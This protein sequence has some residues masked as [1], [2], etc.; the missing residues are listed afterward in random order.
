MTKGGLANNKS[1][2]ALS[3]GAISNILC[4]FHRRNAEV[5]A[6]I[7]D[8]C[9]KCGCGTVSMI[10]RTNVNVASSIDGPTIFHFVSQFWKPKKSFP[11]GTYSLDLSY[12]RS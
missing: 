10:V 3:V 11:R 4:G 8:P 1:N 5:N 12:N 9:D 2:V 7:A 6:L